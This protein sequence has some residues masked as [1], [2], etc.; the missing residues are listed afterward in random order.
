MKKSI[1]CIAVLFLLSLRMFSQEA[2]KKNNLSDYAGEYAAENDNLPSLFILA[3]GGR[4]FAESEK[5]K[6]VEITHIKGEQFEIKELEY[7]IEFARNKEGVV[8]GI[9]CSRPNKKDIIGKRINPGKKNN[10]ALK[11]SGLK[12]YSG[13]Y[14]RVEDENKSHLFITE[15][16]GKLYAQD[17]GERIELTQI[18][19]DS[20]EIKE[21]SAGIIFTRNDIK[22]VDG[23]RIILSDGQE[24]I[25]KKIEKK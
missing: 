20:F 23:I 9:V 16:D 7:L 8:E 25:G 11:V 19:G 12:E 18:K 6:R 2:S 1:Y 5:M 21:M 17:K 15:T 13:E 14:Y 22:A 10:E 4:L 3:E 24:K